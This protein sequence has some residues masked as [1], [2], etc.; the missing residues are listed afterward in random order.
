MKNK[1]DDFEEMMNWLIEQ[2]LKNSPE[3]RK[4]VEE[5]IA[6]KAVRDLKTHINKNK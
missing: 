3:L 5:K 2:W 6:E 4:E 1:E